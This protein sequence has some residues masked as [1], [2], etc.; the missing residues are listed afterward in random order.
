MGRAL[1]LP[2][3][4]PL[5]QASFTA[6]NIQGLRDSLNTMAT[7]RRRIGHEDLGVALLISQLTETWRDL[8]SIKFLL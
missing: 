5:F 3:G 2:C 4:L 1:D 8:V 7:C 6:G